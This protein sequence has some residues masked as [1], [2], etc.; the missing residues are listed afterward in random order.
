MIPV[1]TLVTAAVIQQLLVD[2][3][4]WL[5]ISAMYGRTRVVTRG[6]GTLLVVCTLGS[7]TAVAIIDKGAKGEFEPHSVR[8]CCWSSG[9][10]SSSTY[11]T[12]WSCGALYKNAVLSSFMDVL[13]CL[14]DLGLLGIQEPD[15]PSEISR[16]PIMIYEFAAFGLV[17]YKG[18]KILRG[19]RMIFVN[20][21]HYT[22][23]IVGVLF[24]DSIIYFP[25][26]ALFFPLRNADL[27][28][29]ALG[30]TEFLYC[31]LRRASCLLPLTCALILS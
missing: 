13:V 9:S 15:I 16:I 11:H 2:I 1:W 10:S 12:I 20:S 17:V 27:T 26:C 8:S 24:R 5:R 18:W 30:Y 28:V 31:M 4:L 23:D 3:I 19:R 29:S 22:S 7:V 6:M 21:D 14:L 25:L